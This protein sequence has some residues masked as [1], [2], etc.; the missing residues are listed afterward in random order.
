MKL[1]F[2]KRARFEVTALFTISVWLLARPYAGLWHDG[3]LYTLQGLNILHPDR[4][5]QDLFFFSQTQAKYSIF[6]S[7]LAWGVE[8]TTVREATFLIMFTAGLAFFCSALLLLSRMISGPRL[9][10]G[11]L[12]LALFPHLYG[13]NQ[14]FAFAESFLTARSLAEPFSLLGLAFLVFGQHWLAVLS[15]LLA[16]VLHPL[17]SLPVIAVAMLYL[18]LKDRRFLVLPML[19][20][21]AAL[22]LWWQAWGPFAGLFQVIDAEWRAVLASDPTL[23]LSQWSAADWNV[24]AFDL[25]VLI[26]VSTRLGGNA[27]TLAISLLAWTIFG[28]AATA[29]L[30]DGLA[31]LL[32]TQLQL[33]RSFWLAHCISLALVPWLFSCLKAEAKEGVGLFLLIALVTMDLPGS[34]LASAMVFL[35]VRNST[36]DR[37]A[38]VKKLRWGAGAVIVLVIA[39]DTPAIVEYALE[40]PQQGILRQASLLL[41][42]PALG[43]VIAAYGYRLLQRMRTLPMA[44]VCMLTLVL[45]IVLWDARTDDFRSEIEGYQGNRGIFPEVSELQ[46]VYWHDQP[47]AVWLLIRAP[48]YFSYRQ[49]AGAVYSRETTFE[50]SRRARVL[51]K[52]DLMHA[53]CREEGEHRGR[54]VTCLPS[55]AMLYQTCRSLPD[56]DFVV[57]EGNIAGWAIAHWSPK[58][59]QGQRS[60]HLHPCGAI[61]QALEPPQD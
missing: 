51:K 55:P 48:S 35:L 39:A 18:S 60:Y 13:A 3:L 25:T 11:M 6:P 31:L 5:G 4:Y 30:A 26:L 1:V 28:L 17:V 24:V 29:A 22:V 12:V 32:P 40:N 38:V 8:Q 54:S 46:Q 45:A 14:T 61:R 7:V 41:S 15:L 21:I 50:C 53:V 27:R 49:C 20:A 9:W 57:L 33:W 37:D 34:L 58:S 52:F 59:G 2:S 56:L 16:A 36:R 10:Q 44:T 43:Y 47:L 23:F 19:G 42:V